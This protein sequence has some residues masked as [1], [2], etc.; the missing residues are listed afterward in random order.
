MN[1]DDFDHLVEALS[2]SALPAC[3][4]DLEH[5]VLRRVRR[6]QFCRESIWDWLNGWIPRPAFALATVSIAVVSSVTTSAVLLT[7]HE[8]A[9]SQTARLVLGFDSFSASLSL[10]TDHP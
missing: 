6:A 9:T 2:E 10:P 4:T 3:P 5:N 1:E 7:G 8:A